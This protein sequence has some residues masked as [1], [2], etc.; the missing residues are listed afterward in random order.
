MLFAG[1]LGIV[2]SLVLVGANQFTAPYREANQKAEE[3]RNFLSALDSSIDVNADPQTLIQIFNRDV[4]KVTLGGLTLYEYYPTGSKTGN[5]ASVAVPFAGAGLWGPIKGVI[6]LEPDLETIKGIRFYEQEE[7][8]GLGGEIGSSWFQKEFVGKK[9]VS[10]SGE[11][12]FK[13]LKPGQTEDINSVD[14]ITGATMTSDRVQTIMD[15]LS[16]ALNK[17]RTSHVR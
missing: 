9:I 12:G 16:K 3:I 4:K 2:C 13:V 10:K 8:P 17:E 6:A 1:I 15:N 7:T 11:P 14:G 5:P